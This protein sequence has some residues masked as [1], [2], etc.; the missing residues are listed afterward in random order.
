VASRWF[1]GLV[2]MV[3]GW[4]DEW[5]SGGNGHVALDRGRCGGRLYGE[6]GVGRSR[7][8]FVISEELLGLSLSTVLVPWTSTLH[9][10]TEEPKVCGAF[11][12]RIFFARKSQVHV[13]MHICCLP[14][15][16]RRRRTAHSGGETKRPVRPSSSEKGRG[17]EKIMS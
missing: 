1:L 8:L 13:L 7:P 3:V 9:W 5:Q 6:E 17:D 4:F 14:N 2:G 10:L 15:A 16:S 12:Y 11:R